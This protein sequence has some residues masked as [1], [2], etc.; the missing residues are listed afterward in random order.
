[1]RKTLHSFADLP[2][3]QGQ[4][5]Y[6]DL[7]IQNSDPPGQYPDPQGQYPNPQGQYPNPQGQY[8]EL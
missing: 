2:G 1:M 3:I 8:P 7:M 6:P 5:Q 4:G